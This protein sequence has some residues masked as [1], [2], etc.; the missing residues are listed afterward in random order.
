MAGRRS[1]N[2]ISF[3][4]AR[5]QIIARCCC[6]GACVC[7]YRGRPLLLFRL[8]SFHSSAVSRL[9]HFAVPSLC[10]RACAVLGTGLVLFF[11]ALAFIIG[12]VLGIFA[13]LLI[14]ASRLIV[15]QLSLRGRTPADTNTEAMALNFESMHF[16]GNT[17]SDHREP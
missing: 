3:S 15:F 12:D 16:A 5:F 8:L 11:S 9:E 7:L 10:Y 14:L 4:P 1:S 17:R 2:Y 13:S 6:R